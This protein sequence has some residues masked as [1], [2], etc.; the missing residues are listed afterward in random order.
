M[1]YTDDLIILDLTFIEGRDVMR[2]FW[3]GLPL[4]ADP[5]MDVL[6]S[7]RFAA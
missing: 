2:F 5:L 1:H 6:P 4:S 3:G 7:I